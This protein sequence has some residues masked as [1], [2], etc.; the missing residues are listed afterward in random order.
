MDC[1][2]SQ[3]LKM[4]NEL[5]SLES[6]KST[7]NTLGET[8][9]S[10]SSTVDT[11]SSSISGMIEDVSS[12]K[13]DVGDVKDD[14][15]T[16]KSDVS[17][18][19]DNV[20][21]VITGVNTIGADIKYILSA[22]QDLGNREDYTDYFATGTVVLDVSDNDGYLAYMV[23]LGEYFSVGYTIYQMDTADQETPA[24]LHTYQTGDL[25]Y[26]DNSTYLKMKPESWCYKGEDH[27]NFIVELTNSA[28]ETYPELTKLYVIGRF[29]T[30]TKCYI[31]TESQYELLD[32]NESFNPYKLIYP[33]T[34]PASS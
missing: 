16:V 5:S 7:V 27:Y 29:A 34:I 4:V 20:D 2:L 9:G 6:I 32:N 18:V 11:L 33:L 3:L 14:V 31:L 1:Y 24:Q 8:I 25:V 19:K 15:S 30:R 10:L 21:T 12:I 13:D 26:I 28:V 23:N 22:I 17:D